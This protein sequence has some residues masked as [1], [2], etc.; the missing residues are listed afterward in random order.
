MNRMPTGP[1]SRVSDWFEGHFHLVALLVLGLGFILR[2]QSTS[3]SYL[4]PDESLLYMIAHQVGVAQVYRA[5]LT[6]PHPFLFCVVL[7]FWRLLGDGE[8]ILRLLSV[9]AGTAACWFGF[10]WLVYRFNKTVALIGLLLLTFSPAM[11]S[12][13]AEV[14]QYSLLLLFLTIALYTLERALAERSQVM[15]LWFAAAVLAA[16]VTQYSAMWFTVAVGP[17]AIIRI[18]RD[19]LPARWIALWVGVQL[20]VLTLLVFQYQTHIRP[21]RGSALERFAHDGWL[22]GSYLHPAREGLLP[23]LDRTGNSLFAYLF[24]SGILGPVALVLF[25][26]GVVM[27]FTPQRLMPGNGS[28]G[29]RDQNRNWSFGAMVVA[30]FAANFAA[31]VSGIY[32]F[33]GT[34]HSVFLVL[35]VVAGIG[36]LFGLIAKQRFAHIML[37]V[38]IVVPLWQYEAATVERRSFPDQGREFMVNAI[39]FI[40]DTIPKGSPLF[41]DYETSEL[42][43]YYLGRRQMTTQ[44]PLPEDKLLDLPYGGYR[45]VSTARWSLTPGT[46]RSELRAMKQHC[47]LGPEAPVWVVDGCWGGGTTLDAGL[48]EHDPQCAFLAR[49]AFGRNLAVFKVQAGP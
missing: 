23:F 1:F 47:G 11:I 41:V 6:T 35:F 7:H 3:R 28:P 18:I 2:F 42:L 49:R 4:N 32:P 43:G 38:C 27:M 29:G 48:A 15:L 39:T 25:L 19:R 9:L 20:C 46:F 30:A 44:F 16:S 13:S 17:Y 45:V 31:A 10:K 37:A 14:R 24:S 36:Y 26:S 12:L 21:L 34:R 8:T 5:S 40:R 22:G 33:G